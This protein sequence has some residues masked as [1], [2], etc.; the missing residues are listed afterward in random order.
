MLIYI[1]WIKEEL[2]GQIKAAL[3]TTANKNRGPE[4]EV[5]N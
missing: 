4:K 3:Q 2:L 1:L 5:N